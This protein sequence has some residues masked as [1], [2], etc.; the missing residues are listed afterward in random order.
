MCNALL[1]LKSPEERSL[2]LISW[3]DLRY[4]ELPPGG[5]ADVKTHLF[6]PSFTSPDS[7]NIDTV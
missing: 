6:T 3:N 2:A 5:G 1:Q 4:T 7:F